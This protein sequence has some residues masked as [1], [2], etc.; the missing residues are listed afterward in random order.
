MERIVAR[1]EDS[2]EESLPGS[3]VV[4][5]A[6]DVGL[7]L[8]GLAIFV[9]IFILAG[10][11]PKPSLGVPLFGSV[12]AVFALFYWFLCTLPNRGSPGMQFV[13]RGTLDQSANYADHLRRELTAPAL[14]RILPARDLVEDL[15]LANRIL[16]R[17]ELVDVYGN[18]SFRDARNS[19]RFFLAQ[20]VSPHRVTGDDIFEYDLDGNPIGNDPSGENPDR[21]IHGEIYKARPDVM[22]IVCWRSP[23]VLPFTASTVALLPITQA[24]SFLA[25]GVPIF[26]WDSG[27]A[28]ALTTRSTAQELALTLG[29]KTA[30][31]MR[32]HGALVVANSLHAAV[33][34][35]YYTN[36][37][38][39]LQ[40]Q[41]ILLG[42]NVRYVDLPDARLAATQDDC[43]QTWER[44]KQELHR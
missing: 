42:G 7:V 18:V 21:R 3:Q 11:I 9:G 10:G 16:A 4:G 25:G 33:A 2:S 15:V 20:P 40:A 23:D 41:A 32:G 19:N 37:N 13:G 22:A 24:A 44:W 38:A 5:A 36:L 26:R 28:K 12:F 39:K 27:D 43:E 31:L 6:I 30:A 34:R 8:A 29:D 1:I 14:P 35:A 17:E